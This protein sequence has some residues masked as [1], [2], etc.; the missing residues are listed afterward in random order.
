MGHRGSLPPPGPLPNPTRPWY[1]HLDRLSTGQESWR[2]SL[3][4]AAPGSAGRMNCV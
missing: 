2:W 1:E 3:P 4:P